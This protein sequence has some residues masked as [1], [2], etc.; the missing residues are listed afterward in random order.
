MQLGADV[1]SSVDSSVL[2]S[3]IAVAVVLPSEVGVDKLSGGDW[4]DDVVRSEW[5]VLSAEGW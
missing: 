2:A 3:V 5:V 4:C 1:S